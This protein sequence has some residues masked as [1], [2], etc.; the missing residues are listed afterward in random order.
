MFIASFGPYWAPRLS[1]LCAPYETTIYPWLAHFPDEDFVG[2]E[3][4]YDVPARDGVS[5]NINL[6][7]FAPAWTTGDGKTVY[8]GI[9]QKSNPTI[10]LDGGNMSSINSTIN[11][12]SPSAGFPISDPTVVARYAQVGGTPLGAS[13]PAPGHTEYKGVASFSSWNPQSY[14]EPRIFGRPIICEI[15][16]SLNMT[17][18][19]P[20]EGYNNYSFFG[21]TGADALPY[22]DVTGSGGFVRKYQA[23]IFKVNADMYNLVDADFVVGV[24]YIGNGS[25]G[26]MRIIK[27]G[28]AIES[29]AVTDKATSVY[30][31]YDTITVDDPFTW[32]GAGKS[33]MRYIEIAAN[34]PTVAPFVGHTFP[35]ADASGTTAGLFDTYQVKLAWIV[36]ADTL[37]APN[38]HSPND[39]LYWN[40]RMF[41]TLPNPPL[42]CAPSTAT[43]GYVPPPPDTP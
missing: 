31:L 2:V 5:L 33:N 21:D 30:A 4:A 12:W 15:W 10:Y 3:T 42:L 14:V 43:P 29:V 38:T 32:M 28:V 20:L 8:F 40:P 9:M 6:G 37:L 26:T 35:V 16:Y 23:G 7:G 25:G 13:N 41:Y 36:D 24:S 27:D 18:T 17:R 19:V 22:L 39:F 1:A 11:L 34:T